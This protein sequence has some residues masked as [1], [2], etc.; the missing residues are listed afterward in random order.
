[1]VFAGL[2][3][4]GKTNLLDAIYYLSFTKSYFSKSDSLNVQFET[5]GF[6][7]EGHV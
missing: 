3:G 6:R 4:R 5:D 7:L 1:L 2:N